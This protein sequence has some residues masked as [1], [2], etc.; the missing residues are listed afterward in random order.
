M[1]VQRMTD[2]FDTTTRAQAM[3]KFTCDECGKQADKILSIGRGNR[4]CFQ[5]LSIGLNKMKRV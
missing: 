2:S 1:E 5:C 3:F 4:L